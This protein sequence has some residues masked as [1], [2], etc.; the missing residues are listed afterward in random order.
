[1]LSILFILARLTAFVHPFHVSICDVV[2]NEKARA[3]QI[4]QRVFVDDL[5]LTL[6]KNYGL[7]LVIDDMAMQSQR[8]SLI[9]LY[10]AER[11][12]ILVDGKKRPANYLGSEFEE[13]GIWCY[14]EIAGVKKVRSVQGSSRVLLDEFDDQANIIYFASGEYEK[15]VR[16]DEKNPTVTFTVPGP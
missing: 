11:L 6:N 9:A 4:S 12:E 13:D 2:F 5:E 7:R 10:L 14:I 16:L 1:M 8:D 3:V 15:S